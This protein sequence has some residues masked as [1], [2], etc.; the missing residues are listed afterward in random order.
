[1]PA[2]LRTF[3]SESVAMGHPD[4]VADR[5]AD[6]VLDHMLSAD[7]NARVACEALVS[8]DLV[9]L[10]GEITALDPPDN[11]VLEEIAR[12]TIAAIGYDSWAKGFD[13]ATARA[14][15]SAWGRT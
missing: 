13:A 7:P 10:A 14:M 1:M 9:V 3:T 2:R 11:A 12:N 8:G 5:V 15:S 4:K 6:A